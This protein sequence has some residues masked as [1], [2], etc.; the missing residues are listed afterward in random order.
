LLTKSK[1]QLIHEER[2]AIRLLARELGLS[3]SARVGLRAETHL[4][5]ESIADA[6]GPPPRLRAIR[7][8]DDVAS[9]T[10]HDD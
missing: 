4:P 3:P 2:D 1:A 6:I 5:L 8:R 7:L 10:R 9:E